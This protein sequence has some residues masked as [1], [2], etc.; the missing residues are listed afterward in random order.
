MPAGEHV[1]VA[2]LPCFAESC[3]AGQGGVNSPVQRRPYLSHPLVRIGTQC[4]REKEVG[5]VEDLGQFKRLVGEGPSCILWYVMNA[6][7]IFGE[8]TPISSFL[9][10]R[11]DW[12]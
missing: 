10:S 8:V 11:V 9:L 12:R 7:H 4:I 3:E 2:H 6:L 1:S 5:V